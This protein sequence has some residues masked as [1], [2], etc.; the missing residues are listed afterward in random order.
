MYIYFLS[1]VNFSIDIIHA[2]SLCALCLILSQLALCISTIH[3]CLIPAPHR[4]I[5]FYNK[6]AGYPQF[7]FSASMWAVL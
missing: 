3:A 2:P 7:V 4:F 6:Q 5:L 1:L